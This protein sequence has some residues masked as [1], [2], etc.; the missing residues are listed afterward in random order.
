M[1]FLAYYTQKLR[2]RAKE[3]GIRTKMRVKLAAKLLLIAWTLMKS[4]EAFTPPRLMPS[5]LLESDE[6]AR[7]T[8]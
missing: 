7:E 1:A 6:R 8:T 3:P 2:G 5:A 4:K